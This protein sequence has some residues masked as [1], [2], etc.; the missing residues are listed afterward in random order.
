MSLEVAISVQAAC[1][2][3]LPSRPNSHRNCLPPPP[4]GFL[5]T[6]PLMTLYRPPD[7]RYAKYG[8]HLPLPP[9]LVPPGPA[10]HCRGRVRGGTGRHIGSRSRLL[11]VGRH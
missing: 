5:N 8:R 11:A 7:G 4:S 1:Q 10:A 3:G 6:Q 9:G 2:S